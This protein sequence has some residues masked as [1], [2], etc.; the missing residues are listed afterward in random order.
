LIVSRNRVI[1]SRA[2][3]SRASE[4]LRPRKDH[5]DDS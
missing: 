3:H 2:K 4:K 5:K 1:A